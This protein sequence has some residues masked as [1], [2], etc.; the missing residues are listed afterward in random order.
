MIFN[1]NLKYNVYGSNWDARGDRKHHYSTPLF[2]K[3]KI[4]ALYSGGNYQEKGYALTRLHVF[5]LNGHY[6]ET[7]N[8]GT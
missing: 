4:I 5:I 2:Y 8:V 7:I 6:V 3:D 1:E